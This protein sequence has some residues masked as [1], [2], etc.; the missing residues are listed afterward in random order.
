MAMADKDPGKTYA[1]RG[2]TVTSSPFD[3]DTGRIIG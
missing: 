2:R 3:K 1:T